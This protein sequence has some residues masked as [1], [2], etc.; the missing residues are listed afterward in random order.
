MHCREWDGAHSDHG[1]LAAPV[2][3]PPTPPVRAVWNGLG[4]VEARVAAG[5]TMVPIH[6]RAVPMLVAIDASDVRPIYH[7]IV[8]EV[9]RALV[10]G[11]L[12]PGAALPSLRP[13]AAVRVSP[14]R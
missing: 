14:T 7:Q 9:R 3:R 13:L 2:G 5:R 11:A 12:E 4:R 1:E 6:D 10:L 8:G